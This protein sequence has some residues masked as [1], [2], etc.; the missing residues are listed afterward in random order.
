VDNN[1]SAVRSN[2]RWNPYRAAC[3]VMTSE[4]YPDSS[5][6][7]KIITGIDNAEKN[8]G[9]IV[10]HAGTKEVNGRIVTN[11]GRVLGV[12]AIGENLQLAR[13]H[14]YGAVGKIS[15]EGAKWRQDIGSAHLRRAEHG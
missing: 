11:G 13:N 14:A 6:P 15:F 1:L 2:L 8:K 5:E 3:V 4:N 12:T 10:Y 7:G 9:I